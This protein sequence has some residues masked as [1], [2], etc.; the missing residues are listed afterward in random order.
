MQKSKTGV[1]RLLDRP[2][3]AAYLNVSV[4]T[5]IRLDR[6]GLLPKIKLGGKAKSRVRYR[7]AD[8]DALIASG[9]M[10]ATSGPLA[11]K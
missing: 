3:A 4:A 5:V 10:P 11:A 9:Y 6:D 8:L 7:R 2:Q 1:D